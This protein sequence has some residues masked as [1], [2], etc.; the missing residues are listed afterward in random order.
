MKSLNETAYITPYNRFLDVGDLIVSQP[1]IN[2][3]PT[4]VPFWVSA[5]TL[6]SVEKQAGGIHESTKS[7]LP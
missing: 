6:R 2:I 5:M 4:G 7:Y 3:A 1:L